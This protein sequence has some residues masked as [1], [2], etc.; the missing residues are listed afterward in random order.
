M[1]E[2]GNARCSKAIGSAALAGRLRK[3]A[4][5]M[6]YINDRALRMRKKSASWIKS[7]F[8]LSNSWQLSQRRADHVISQVHTD[9]AV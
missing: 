6:I 9:A 4:A 8:R 7:D 3:A 1:F 5:S 2:S